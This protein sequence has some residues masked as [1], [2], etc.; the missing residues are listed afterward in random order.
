LPILDKEILAKTIVQKI[1]DMFDRKK[2][3]IE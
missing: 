3:D 2:S 1:V